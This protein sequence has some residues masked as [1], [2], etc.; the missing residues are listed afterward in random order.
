MK[1]G[2]FR[3]LVDM[4]NW[5]RNDLSGST[6]QEFAACNVPERLNQHIERVQAAM[7][8]IAPRFADDLGRATRAIEYAQKTIERWQ[9]AQLVEQPPV[10]GEI[11]SAFARDGLKLI[12]SVH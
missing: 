9:A 7:Q 5:S 6:R 10:R 12:H 1:I 3:K 2:E 8:E 11:R 4:L